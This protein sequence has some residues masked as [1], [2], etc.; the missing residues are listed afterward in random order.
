M[1][2]WEVPILEVNCIPKIHE[3]LSLLHSQHNDTSFQYFSHC[4][5]YSCLF[6]SLP[7]MLVYKFLR[8]WKNILINLSI[9]CSTQYFI[10]H[11]I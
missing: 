1:I 11:T 3:V 8:V 6:L 7:S 9:P 10:L 4:L 5:A 2:L